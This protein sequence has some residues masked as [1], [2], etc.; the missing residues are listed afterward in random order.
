M[1]AHQSV[2][3]VDA[4]TRVLVRLCITRR[5]L[6][7]WVTADRVEAV[8]NSAAAVFRRMWQAPVVALTITLIVAALAPARLLLALPIVV[9]WLV[10]PALAHATGQPLAHRRLALG[11]SDRLAIRKLARRIWLF[12]EEMVGPADNHLVPDNCQPTSVCSCYPP[13]R[14]TTSGM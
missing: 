7:E 1:L 9:L 3:M 14:R 10:S 4:I 5:S 8:Q 13:C 6:L 2:V 11:R 12:F